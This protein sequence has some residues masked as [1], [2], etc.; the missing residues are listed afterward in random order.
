M[1]V[2]LLV[3]AALAGEDRR[4][5]LGV[6]LQGSSAEDLPFEG[7]GTLTRWHRGAMSLEGEWFVAWR[8]LATNRV[9]QEALWLLAGGEPPE[10]AAV[11]RTM[12][13]NTWVSA[14]L[15]F[16][17]WRLGGRG[18]SPVAYAGG[19]VRL[20]EHY[21]LT[22]ED[23][24]WSYPTHELRRVGPGGGPVLGAGLELELDGWAMHLRTLGRPHVYRGPGGGV[25]YSGDFVLS[26][27]VTMAV[28]A[29]LRGT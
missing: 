25:A 2:L 12:S 27:G 16:H 11:V 15:G 17:P 9:E 22:I 1:F 3:G 14:L 21:E 8:P 19:Q 29:P 13:D 26:F 23:D 6:N 10:R 4:W 7:V 28:T 18:V 5:E 24:Y 20:I